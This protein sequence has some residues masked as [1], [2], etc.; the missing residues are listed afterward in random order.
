MSP[1]LESSHSQQVCPLTGCPLFRA[2]LGRIP[3]DPCAITLPPCLHHFPSSPAP[4]RPLHPPRDRIVLGR[5]SKVGPT[6]GINL[7]PSRPRLEWPTMCPPTDRRRRLGSR[8]F[9]TSGTLHM[10][11]I[12]DAHQPANHPNCKPLHVSVI[13]KCQVVM[14]GRCGMEMDGNGCKWMFWDG[15]SVS[16]AFPRKSQAR[17]L[18]FAG[19]SSAGLGSRVPESC[20]QSEVSRNKKESQCSPKRERSQ[21]RQIPTIPPLSLTVLP[22]LRCLVTYLPT[23][24]K[25]CMQLRVLCF[26]KLKAKQGAKLKAKMPRAACSWQLPV[27]HIDWFSHSSSILIGQVS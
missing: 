23:T 19:L 18:V 8:A 25:H 9:W 27:K 26:S 12:L 24:S 2:F 3:A 17:A 6:L 11:R 15:S 13:C 22:K 21:G 16:G 14:P 10:V 7:A 5:L 1:A 4:F 20:M